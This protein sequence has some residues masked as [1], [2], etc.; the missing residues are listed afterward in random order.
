[1]GGGKALC[2]S[3]H[4]HQQTQLISL[5]ANGKNISEREETQAVA[6]LL[7]TVAESPQSI[8]IDIFLFRRIIW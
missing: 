4:Q 2:L 3:V 7:G 5:S 1:M 8:I 6:L